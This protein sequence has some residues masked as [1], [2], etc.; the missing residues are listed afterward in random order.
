MACLEEQLT[1]RDKT[2]LVEGERESFVGDM[3]WHAV[4]LT[5]SI[6]RM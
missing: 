4:L 3:S 1:L 5:L 6:F 2:F